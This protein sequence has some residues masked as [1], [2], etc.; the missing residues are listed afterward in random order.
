MNTTKSQASPGR[1][2]LSAADA[3]A[4]TERVLNLSQAEQARVTIQAGRRSFTRSADNRI[5]TA[6]G[7]TDVSVEIMSVF[8]KR[9]ASVTTNRLDD[10]ELPAAVRRSE[11]LA[12][13]APENP[14]YM[15]ELAQQQYTSVSGYYDST[16][17]MAPD[18]FAAATAHTIREASGSGAVAAGYIDVR[19]GSQTL[20]TSNGLFAHHPATGVASTLTV[21]M[22]DGSSSGW[23]GDEAADWNEIET[24]R[25]AAAAVRK[26]LD[27]RNKTSLEP[28]RY[29]TILEPTAVGMLMLRMLNSFNAR[30]ADEGRSYYSRQGGGNRIGERLFDRRVTMVSDP[31]V[32][33]AEAAPFSDEGLP[34]QR[35]MWVRDGMLQNLAYS[36]FWGDRQDVAPKP[37][38]ANLIM[39]GGNDSLAEMIASTRRGVLITRFWYIRGLNPRIISYTGLTRDGTFLIENGRISRPV[40]NFRFNQS[41]ADML[42]NIE[43]IGRPVRVAAGENSS[44]GMPIVVPALKV[45]DFHLASVSDAI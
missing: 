45:R 33:D 41:L 21:R 22:P 39:S 28:G 12:R 13:L 20:A 31:V 37:R 27:W 23:G 1:H 26:C 42:L 29:T 9:V 2:G 38:P 19:A 11:E 30:P 10:D 16:G 43:M 34:R 44:V 14:E 40:T 15:G 35:T 3:R 18:A 7:S 36:R 4:V 24:E 8:G 5:T 17:G 6:G 25:I 32:R